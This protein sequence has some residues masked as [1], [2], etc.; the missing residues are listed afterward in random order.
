MNRYAHHPTFMR[1]I[2]GLV[3][4]LCCSV[5]SY[6]QEPDNENN[7]AELFT[8]VFQVRPDFLGNPS[9]TSNEDP[10]ADLSEVPGTRT[11]AQEI[12]EEKG[13]T[14]PKGASAFYNPVTSAL[15]VRNIAE[16]FDK[17]HDLL[18]AE[19][20]FSKSLDEVTEDKGL[21]VIIELIETD[22]NAAANLI[23][24]SMAL[25]HANGLRANL[26]EKIKKRTATITQSSFLRSRL[27]E[28][29]MAAG[30]DHLHP[31]AWNEPK[32]DS[33]D[34]HDKAAISA[35]A[36]AQSFVEEPTGLRVKWNAIPVT[37]DGQLE[38]EWSIENTELLGKLSFGIGVSEIEKP[39]FYRQK[40]STRVLTR[41][42]QWQLLGTFS[43]ESTRDD[44]RTLIL[45]R[46][47]SAAEKYPAV[48]EAVPP[49]EKPHENTQ[50]GAMLEYI[51][52]DATDATALLQK[53]SPASGDQLL[54][55]ATDLIDKGKARR[56]ET[57]YVT[58]LFGHS[59][60]NSFVQSERQIDYPSEWSP[61]EIMGSKITGVVPEDTNLI[62]PATIRE[63]ETQ[64][65]GSIL[66]LK[67]DLKGLRLHPELSRHDG[68][69][70]YGR[71]E[72]EVTM[73]LISSI[74]IA[75]QVE[76]FANL[77]ER[78][79]LFLG[80]QIPIRSNTHAPDS[81]KRVLI[82]S[83]LQRR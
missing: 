40:L 13:I 7:P 21:R 77:P 34:D 35:H 23:H 9:D 55:A 65:V 52:V 76:S 39:L 79:T 70:S 4:F 51:E 6:S 81:N 24:E 14:F 74:V 61:P 32:P 69:D 72:A 67:G 10:F 48:T 43:P 73:P 5:S 16:N 15:I 58:S 49:P 56:T 30:S 26:E 20:H 42:G 71:D 12:L 41:S 44:S 47:E 27:G 83:T 22:H 11:T 63:W 50:L 57:M 29:R 37:K 1:F 82:F 17:L 75:E 66:S 45:V 18:V 60:Q 25:P 68:F 59:I 3:V 62:I 31:R 33:N 46:V 28:S 19:G 2:I 8:R 78:Q 36:S 80:M 38:I 64:M 53:H 54:Q